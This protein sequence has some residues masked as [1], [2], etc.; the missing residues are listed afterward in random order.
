MRIRLLVLMAVV[1]LPAVAVWAADKHGWEL[2]SQYWGELSGAS[3]QPTTLP[4]NE[5]M[6]DDVEH[7]I[8]TGHPGKAKHLLLKWEANHK[9][10]PVR[11][12]CIY[13]IAEAAYQDDNRIRAFYY[14]DELMD[15]YPA[16]N[17]YS[18]ALQKQFD[19]AD[20]YLHGYC[21]SFLGLAILDETDAAVAMMFRIQQRS[22]GSP[23]AEKALMKTANYYFD[24]QD[25]DFAAD[26]FK[27]Y[28][29]NYP[30]SPEVPMCRLKAAQS[31]LAM[32]HGVPY[33]V[34]SIIDARTQMLDIIRDYP[35]LAREHGLPGIIANVDNVFSRKILWV[36]AFYER[37][38]LPKAAV[39][40]YRFLVRTY[41]DSPEAATARKRLADMSPDDLKEPQPPMAKGY[42][43]STQP[44]NP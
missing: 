30:R 37:T 20:A 15:E 36:G 38:H 26:A 7:L 31:S 8:L 42:A 4:G 19:I 3:S 25:F 32:Y 22:P 24:N 9:D 10:S 23:L 17:L 11:D 2:Q 40:Q 5:P 41:P 21:D 29:R 12:R 14:L 43:P 39:Y 28:V 16:S 27:Q 35:D 18:V 1:A 34:T 6:L 33:D 44:S 13:L